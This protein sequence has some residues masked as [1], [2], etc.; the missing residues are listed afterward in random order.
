MLPS[1]YQVAPVLASSAFGVVWF[2]MYRYSG[3]HHGISLQQDPR[4]SGRRPTSRGTKRRG[5]SKL[6]RNMIPGPLV[7]GLYSYRAN[8][9]ELE[10]YKSQ[11]KG[12]YP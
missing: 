9:T 4:S 8:S 7:D 2:G 1:D 11:A 6:A 3:E 5:R 12:E 10:P